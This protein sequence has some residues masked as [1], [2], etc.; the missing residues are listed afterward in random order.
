MYSHKY[1]TCHPH[2]DFIP[3][4]SFLDLVQHLP[5]V[6]NPPSTHHRPKSTI[7]FYFYRHIASTVTHL[8]TW[9][10]ACSSFY[11]LPPHHLL[12]HP[13]VTHLPLLYFAASKAIDN[14][15]HAHLTSERAHLSARAIL[16]RSS[17]QLLEHSTNI[18]ICHLILFMPPPSRIPPVYSNP[19]VTIHSKPQ[20]YIN[21]TVFIT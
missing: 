3:H 17:H 14:H 2:Y 20:Y 13:T 19:K 4:P 10:S 5:T 7:L 6:N 1:C 15:T 12:E 18:P 11:F 21:E 8:T 9:Q 16:F